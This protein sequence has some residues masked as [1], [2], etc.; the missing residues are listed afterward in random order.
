MAPLDVGP[1]GWCRRN[2]DHVHRLQLV[3][4]VE[5]PAPRWRFPSGSKVERPAPRWR[6]PGARRVE[7]PAQLR[8]SPDDSPRGGLVKILSLLADLAQT[9]QQQKVHAIGLNW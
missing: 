9:D 6:F 2:F 3:R 8:R 5:R 1:M 4:R 7:R